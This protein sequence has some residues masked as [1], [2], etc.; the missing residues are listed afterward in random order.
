MKTYLAESK[1]AGIQNPEPS[2]WKKD[3]LHSPSLDVL[4]SGSGYLCYFFNL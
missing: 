3:Q 4:N 1:L 2:G